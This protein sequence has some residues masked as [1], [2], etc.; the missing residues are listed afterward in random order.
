MSF[1]KFSPNAL[2]LFPQ[3]L[4]YYISLISSHTWQFP[5]LSLLFM[6]LT[7][8]KNNSNFVECLSIWVSQMFS[9]LDCSYAFLTGIWQKWCCVLL[10]TSYQG[11]CDVHVLS[12]VMLTVISAEAG[13]LRE[14]FLL[15]V[16]LEPSK[17][18]TNSSYCYCK[19]QTKNRSFVIR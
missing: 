16:V 1:T 15:A 17:S 18:S 10:S 7:L 9:W 11:V 4:S 12:G 3:S 6:T 5:N 2:F 19:V 13:N 8:L 14:L